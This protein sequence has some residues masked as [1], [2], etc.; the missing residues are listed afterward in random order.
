MPRFSYLIRAA[1]ATLCVTTTLAHA[2]PAIDDDGLLER[3]QRA[4]AELQAVQAELDAKLA[5]ARAN[6]AQP[7]P[8]APAVEPA[9]AAATAAVEPASAT[10]TPA[11]PPV[12]KVSGRTFDPLRLKV[13]M[14]FPPNVRTIQQATQYLLETANYKLALSPTNPEETRQIL[15]RPLLPQDRDGS[16]KA[17]E[18]ALLQ[19]SGDDT[20]L[21]ID[22]EHKM[23]SFE[24]HKP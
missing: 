14:H 18:D 6:R 19:I 3:L 2:V 20:V 5:S 9:A 12:V 22:R 13:V 17:I 23:L 15:S 4:K 10:D 24:F 7:A 16:L 21:I 8:D 1:V 11:D